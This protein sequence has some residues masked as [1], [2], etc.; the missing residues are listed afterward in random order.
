MRKPTT[1][2]LLAGAVLAVHAGA[3]EGGQSDDI[4]AIERAALDRWG[5]GDPG[6]F[7][8]TYAPEVTYFD[9]MQERR[10]DG[11]AAMRSLISPV[12]G[13]ISV[14]RYEMLR[15]RVQRYGALAVLTYQL[16]NYEKLPDGSEVPT[17]RWNSTAVFRKIDGRWRSVHS[18]WSFTKP[19]L[20]A[21]P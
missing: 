12:A 4:I 6:G 1:V 21:P 8:N 18:H 7:L 13:Q 2:I 10:V 5:K 19:Q 14:D 20:R 11:L 3:V 15:P 9:P 17:T 16:V